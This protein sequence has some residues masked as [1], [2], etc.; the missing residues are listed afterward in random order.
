MNERG[1]TS[2]ASLEDAAPVDKITTTDDTIE[3]PSDLGLGRAD[4]TAKVEAAP[5]ANKE[6]E[7]TPERRD[8]VCNNMASAACESCAL[9][10]NCPILMLKNARANQEK[11][12][13]KESY[14]EDLLSGNEGIVVAGYKNREKVNT[15]QDLKPKAPDTKPKVVEIEQPEPEIPQS[16]IVVTEVVAPA[17]QP[18]EASQIKIPEVAI[19]IESKPV[20][21]SQPIEKTNPVVKIAPNEMT[22]N[23]APNVNSPEVITIKNS[24]VKLVKSIDNIVE[25]PQPAS[26]AQPTVEPVASAIKEIDRHQSAPAKAHLEE[27]V[28][29]GGDAEVIEP[30]QAVAEAEADTTSIYLVDV[31][32]RPQEMSEIATNQAGTVEK[33]SEPSIELLVGASTSDK[34]ILIGEDMAGQDQIKIETEVGA[35][36]EVEFASQAIAEVTTDLPI[37]ISEPS[38]QLPDSTIDIAVIAPDIAYTTPDV[39]PTLDLAPALDVVPEQDDRE[40]VTTPEPIDLIDALP[41]D[42]PIRLA[43]GEVVFV[44]LPEV[45]IISVTVQEV[46]D[47]SLDDAREVEATIDNTPAMLSQPEETLGD[48]ALDDDFEVAVMDYT[49]DGRDSSPDPEL[50]ETDES[51]GDHD[52]S[53]TNLA[54]SGGGSLSGHFGGVR[55][56][57]VIGMLAIFMAL[58]TKTARTLRIAKFETLVS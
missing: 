40:I 11:K 36:A 22:S 35:R 38:D 49:Q 32:E 57:A 28:A 39:V 37:E 5:E 47:R 41:I 56:V 13:E 43:D 15:A 27:V 3:I 1:G 10:S 33:S 18:V 46:V 54:S 29:S 23:K 51:V 55:Q 2:V 25:Q 7:M 4:S 8:A 6:V 34:P 14:L 17:P 44:R 19:K 12:P 31:A 16:P 45:D 20:T 50:A 30:I 53:L 58:K 42:S 21:V 9:V 26:P 48:I 24:P 52:Y